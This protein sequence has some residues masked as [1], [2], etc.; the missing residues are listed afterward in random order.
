MP[1]CQCPPCRS[2]AGRVIGAILFLPRHRDD[3]VAVAGA[4]FAASLS[5]RFPTAP[6]CELRLGACA[7]VGPL[8]PCL[9]VWRSE[10]AD[11]AVALSDE[12]A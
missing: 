11:S 4:A 1:G 5:R 12:I 8:A 9:R 3:G 7:Q 10:R 6:A 2:I